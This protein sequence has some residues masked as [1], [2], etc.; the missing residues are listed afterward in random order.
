MLPTIG[1][2]FEPN[3]LYQGEAELGQGVTDL[4]FDIPNLRAECGPAPAHTR[5][6]WY[7]S[8]INIP[9]A[10][11]IGS[12][13]DE[14]AHAAGKD[15]K[16][17]LLQLLGPDRLVDQKKA[18]L[19]VEAWNYDRSFEEYPID[20]ARYRRVVERAATESGW[21]TPL[22]KGRGRGIAVHRSF[23][24][25]V[26]TV[27]DVEVQP[28][29]GIVIP[30]V[31][32]AVDA[33]SLIHPERVRAQMEGATIMGIGNTLLGEITFKDGRVVQSNYTDYQVAR[34][35]AAPARAPRPSGRERRASGWR[36]RAGRAA[37]GAGALQRDLRGDGAADP[38][39]AGREAARAVGGGA[40]SV[41]PFLPSGGAH[42]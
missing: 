41:E 6:G 28:D 8:V 32:V 29:G 30:R 12:F 35:D 24:S 31:D 19:A 1:A 20:V 21:G 18:G 22:P 14:L 36:G 33:G 10:F 2:T 17:F 39:P 27:V 25:Y 9:H 34:M 38:E 4:P 15:P 13:A 11:A 16:E 7:R 23:V 26:A 37:G 5:I 3:Q 42:G 40:L